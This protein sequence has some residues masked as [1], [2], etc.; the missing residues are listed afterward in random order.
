M[1]ELTEI[2]I[3]KMLTTGRLT[4]FSMLSIFK[5]G[6]LGEAETTSELSLMAS[7]KSSETGESWGAVSGNSR[8]SS[9]L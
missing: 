1:F 8:N 9:E 5:V 4:D 7:F 3:L 2:S 6:K